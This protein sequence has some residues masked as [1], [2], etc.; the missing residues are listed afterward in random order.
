MISILEALK[1]D[2]VRWH[3]AALAGKLK[4]EFELSQE[5][6]GLETYGFYLFG[7]KRDVP[8]IVGKQKTRISMCTIYMSHSRSPK[9]IRDKKSNMV[10]P[11]MLIEVVR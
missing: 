5:I 2:V 7:A 6:R 11:A 9:I 8:R 3:D 1:G 4:I 10:I